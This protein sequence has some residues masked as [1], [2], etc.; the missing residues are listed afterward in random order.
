MPKSTPVKATARLA[1]SSDPVRGLQSDMALKQALRLRDGGHLGDAL[2]LCG[3]IL[4]QDPQHVGTLYL[5]GTLAHQ[6]GALD[7]A[8]DCLRQA[9]AHAPHSWEVRVALGNA[10]ATAK[11]H[12]EAMKA[13]KRA[14]SL[15]G[16]AF[17]AHRGLGQVQVELGMT[18]GALRSFEQALALRPDDLQSAYFMAALRQRETAIPGEGY[19]AALFDS[20]ADGFDAHLTRL[21][22]RL[23]EI[24]AD[25]L[26]A[27]AGHARLASALDIGCGTGLVGLAIRDQVDAV[28]G[29]D[30]SRSMIDKAGAHGLYRTLGLGE[31]ADLLRN[32]PRFA[33]PYDLVTAADV[34]IYV[35][36]LDEI[37]ATVSQK[38]T[39]SGLF[40]F[41][42]EVS[43]KA[44]VLIQGSGRFGHSRE[45]VAAL[46]ARHSLTIEEETP[47]Q[48]REEFGM[49][50]P[51][52][53]YTLRRTGG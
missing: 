39:S 22:Y 5:M 36:R 9:A 32:D 7:I 4:R 31:A 12:A 45:Y 3:E 29:V 43:A 49:A 15:N 48:L 50:V 47:L 44:D 41:S 30:V 21:G 18:A 51:G 19:V 37:F 46:A 20:Y 35:G 42:V 13:F 26:A 11:H 40:V 34:F 23:P 17:T 33:G 28:D 6:L 8:T 53:L 25:R 24:I 14:I 2:R 10:L 52:L 16:A 38:L 27:R 1:P